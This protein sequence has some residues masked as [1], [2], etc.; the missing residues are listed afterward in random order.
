MGKANFKLNYFAELPDEIIEK[1]YRINHEKLMQKMFKGRYFILARKVAFSEILFTSRIRQQ[2]NG[3]RHALYLNNNARI[4]P[5][6]YE[7]KN[8]KPSDMP[9]FKR[10]QFAYSN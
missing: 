10:T 7:S 9:Y 5:D 2:D 1:I 8:I 6:K 4:N 3:V